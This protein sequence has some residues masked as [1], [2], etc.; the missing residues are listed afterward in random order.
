MSKTTTA[1]T[2]VVHSRAEAA[3]VIPIMLGFHPTESVIIVGVGTG[4]P[5]ARLD[6]ISAEVSSLRQT[7]MP[8]IQAGHW[9]QGCVIAI[10]TEDDLDRADVLLASAPAWLPDVPIL[11][12]FR[13]TE[14]QCFDPWEAVGEPVAEIPQLTGHIAASREELVPD[15]QQLQEPDEVL[16]RAIAAW[17]SGSGAA[18]WIHLDRLEELV[19]GTD[20]PQ[21]AQRLVALLQTAANPREVDL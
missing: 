18:A 17:K 10:F 19:G 20:L 16:C 1:T 7:L 4:T 21:R 3:A 6:L 14:G 11:D 9:R 13:V 8:A 5:T 15:V 12:A 2:I